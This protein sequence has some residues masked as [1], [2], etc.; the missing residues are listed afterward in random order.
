MGQAPIILN[1]SILTGKD[2]FTSTSVGDT[3]PSLT[4]TLKTD[5]DF[6]YDEDK[7]AQ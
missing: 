5:P 6:K 2:G 3:R 7:V 4:T 1:E